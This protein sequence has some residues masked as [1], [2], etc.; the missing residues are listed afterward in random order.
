MCIDSYM[1]T[2]SPSLACL[3]GVFPPTLVLEPFISA[4]SY[5][6][7][8]AWISHF[9]VSSIIPCYCFSLF[10]FYSWLLLLPRI[11]YLF[12]YALNKWIKAGT[13]FFTSVSTELSTQHNICHNKILLMNNWMSKLI[14]W[15]VNYICKFL[16][17]TLDLLN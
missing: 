5:Q 16:G 17:S 14:S 7:G 15:D 1:Y 4:T 11:L 10:Y 12:I 9:A 6:G 8:L 3:K 2:I 13:L